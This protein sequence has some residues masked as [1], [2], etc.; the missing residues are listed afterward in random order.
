MPTRQ[1]GPAKRN[2]LSVPLKREEGM[3]HTGK[4]DCPACA[5]QDIYNNWDPT[6]DEIDMSVQVGYSLSEVIGITAKE[7]IDL[8][9][10]AITVDEMVARS[11]VDESQASSL[12]YTA[13]E[14]AC[15]KAAR[16]RLREYLS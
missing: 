7:Y 8:I 5:D 9:R 2:T 14:E 6:N 13:A 3:R 4:E 1:K 10:W 11:E 12:L 16:R 15:Q